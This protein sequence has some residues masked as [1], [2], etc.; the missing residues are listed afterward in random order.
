MGG[1]QDVPVESMISYWMPFG[2]VVRGG[3]ETQDG[4]A[5]SGAMHKVLSVVRYADQCWDNSF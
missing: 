3:K 5:A 2:F 1:R 4:F